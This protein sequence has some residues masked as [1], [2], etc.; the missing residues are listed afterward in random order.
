MAAL[1]LPRPLVEKCLKP[2]LVAAGELGTTTLDDGRREEATRTLAEV[3]EV[4]RIV[5]RLRI[6]GLW[7]SDGRQLAL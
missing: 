3:F 1:L 6:A 5:A 7:G 2:F 4:N